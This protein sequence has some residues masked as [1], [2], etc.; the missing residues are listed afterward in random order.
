MRSTATRHTPET[1]P[2]N[3]AEVW[4]QTAAEKVV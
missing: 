3:K 4:M 2:E 1:D